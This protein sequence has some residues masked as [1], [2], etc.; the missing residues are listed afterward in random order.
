MSL[1][2][3]PLARRF[4]SDEAVAVIAVVASVRRGKQIKPTSNFD[5]QLRAK[6]V[7]NVAYA[8]LFPRAKKYNEKLTHE[9]QNVSNAV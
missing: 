5:S 7:R 8:P 3:L 2:K 9:A 1:S 4:P 6:Q